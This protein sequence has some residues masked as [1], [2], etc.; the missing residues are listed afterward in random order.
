MGKNEG[1]RHFE[2]EPDVVELIDA[3]KKDKGISKDLTV[4][5]SIEYFF[6]AQDGLGLPLVSGPIVDVGEF[7]RAVATGGLPDLV[8]TGDGGVQRLGPRQLPG[9]A[10]KP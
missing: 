9:R 1:Y 2:L 5:K 3:Q 6:E 8:R 10:R 4:N 7:R